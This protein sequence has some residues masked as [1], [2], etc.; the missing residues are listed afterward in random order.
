MWNYTLTLFGS[1]SAKGNKNL[2]VTGE[3]TE[4]VGGAALRGSTQGCLW[5][6]LVCGPSTWGQGW[7]AT[8]S[9]NQLLCLSAFQHCSKYLRE[10]NLETERFL[11][12]HNFHPQLAGLQFGALGD[13]LTLVGSRFWLWVLPGTEEKSKGGFL[14]KSI[15]PGMGRP[16]RALTKSS[17][18]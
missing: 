9:P 17:A 4:Q 12:A 11:S 2:E 15:F 1:V 3:E 14:S 16:I 13:Y 18:S 5:G 7:E 10:I 6:G 8:A